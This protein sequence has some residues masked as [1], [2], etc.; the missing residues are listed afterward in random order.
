[1][2]KF[3]LAFSM[4]AFMAIVSCKED[5]PPPPPP[6]PEPQIIVVPPP[7]PPP[8]APAKEVEKDG[9]SISVGSDGVEI[10]TKKGDKKTVIDV[11]DGKG[12]IEIKK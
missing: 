5:T 6:V 12:K 3:V 2:K 4:L 11:K 7:P 9:T 1:M 8:P 10:S